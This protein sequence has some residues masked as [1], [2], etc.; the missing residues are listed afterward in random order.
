[1]LLP[2]LA[3]LLSCWSTPTI[4]Q[5]AS[6][7]NR[8]IIIKK[9]IDENGVETIEKTIKEGSDVDVF[10]WNNQ[11]GEEMSF[12]LS[13]IDEDIQIRINGDNGEESFSWNTKDSDLDGLKERLKE[14]DFR[15]NNE[16]GNL[17]LNFN[18]DNVFNSCNDNKGK[19]FLGVVMEES[20]QNENGVETIEGVSDQGVTIQEVVN[21]SAAEAAG[22]QSGDIITAIDGK[23]TTRISNVSKAIKAKKV[24][25]V[26]NV[27]YIRNGNSMQTTATL[28]SKAYNNQKRI[29]SNIRHFDI[30]VDRSSS[31]K[32]DP[33]KVFIGVYTG[34][35]HDSR[36]LRVNGVIENTPAF[37]AGLIKGD[38]ILALDGVQVSSHTELLAERNKHS[39]GDEFT[40][41]Y[42]RDGQTNT[43]DAQFKECKEE[44]IAPQVEEK[45]EE[46]T[47][48][49]ATERNRT[50]NILDI[51]LKAFPNPTSSAV[52]VRFVG[53]RTATVVTATD[54]KG[55]EIYREELNNFDGLYN[56]KINLSGAASGAVIITV[57]QGNKISSKKVLYTPDRA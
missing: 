1:M 8:V 47:E 32:V 45:I 17:F 51:N 13:E 31:Y 10:T 41:T 6:D 26:I 54:V 16:N 30:D 22:L 11:N 46:N 36:G 52:N 29:R 24:G 33:C 50:N 20:V 55:K 12:D 27:S 38:R 14:L 19:P 7:Q 53:E 28:K 48:E 44:K 23:S 40:I 37:D 15:M 9:S 56:K 21:G 3:I 43:V 42:V 49:N 25:D 35:G 18:E 2:L 5:E 34:T 39:Q 4:A 57:R